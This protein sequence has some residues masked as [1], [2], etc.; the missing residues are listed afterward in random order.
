MAGTYTYKITFKLTTA[1][2]K[3]IITGHVNLIR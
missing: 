2:D 3:Q 1:E